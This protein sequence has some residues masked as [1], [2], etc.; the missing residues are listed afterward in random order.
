[1]LLH[2]SSLQLSLQPQVVLRLLTWFLCTLLIITMT[3]A[4]P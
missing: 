2:N 4:S 1:M 3:I